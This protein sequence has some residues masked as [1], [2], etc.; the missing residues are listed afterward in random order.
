M[1][2]LKLFIN[3]GKTSEYRFRKIDAFSKT[4]NLATSR[5]MVLSFIF[6]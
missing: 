5:D 3:S 2:Y 4:L 1:N 6:D